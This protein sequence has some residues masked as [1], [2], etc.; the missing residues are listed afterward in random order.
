[1]SVTAHLA[2]LVYRDSNLARIEQANGFEL[3]GFLGKV[4][5]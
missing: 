2:I 3:L 5:V 4:T 1:M